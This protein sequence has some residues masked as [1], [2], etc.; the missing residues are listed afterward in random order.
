MP[1]LGAH[2]ARAE[3]RFLSIN[4]RLHLELWLIERSRAGLRSEIISLFAGDGRR[5]R[6]HGVSDGPGLALWIDRREI[7][8][9]RG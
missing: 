4:P 2:H 3:R 8:V 5:A 1:A 6:V 7:Y 9:K